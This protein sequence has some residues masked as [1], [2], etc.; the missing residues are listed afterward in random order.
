MSFSCRRVI[1]K[2]TE[3]RNC[4]SASPGAAPCPA[5]RCILLP[6][7][8]PGQKQQLALRKAD[9][10]EHAGK[11]GMT[12]GGVGGAPQEGPRSWKETQ[13]STGFPFLMLWPP[14]RGRSLW[15]RSLQ[16]SRHASGEPGDTKGAEA[17][18]VELP[19][20]ILTPPGTVLAV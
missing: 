16:H 18:E 1:G 10:M 20:P 12:L 4:H 5:E 13:Q 17:T 2:E 6:P 7:G 14:G 15:H 11:H 19:S 8:P 9:S 3:G